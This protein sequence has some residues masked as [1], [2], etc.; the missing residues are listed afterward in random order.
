[1]AQNAPVSAP[2]TMAKRIH[3]PEFKAEVALAAMT[4]NKTL[5]EL[6]SI[7]DLHPVQVC[8]WKKQFAKRLPEL[9]K[10]SELNP[11]Q[12]G[13]DDLMRQVGRLK[14]AND[15]LKD[16][17]EWQKKTLQLQPRDLAIFPGARSSNYFTAS[18]V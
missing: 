11:N 4:G 12:D 5:A 17:I 10:N 9:F 1:M 14:A 6:A 2:L 8:Q 18:P 7:Y 15:A 3:S 16:E 13:G